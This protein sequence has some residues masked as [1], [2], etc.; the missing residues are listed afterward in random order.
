VGT[1]DPRS[2]RLSQHHREHPPRQQAGRSGPGWRK[3]PIAR[4]GCWRTRTRSISTSC[5]TRTTSSGNRPRARCWIPK[6]L[7]ARLAA[8][9]RRLR[10]ALERGG[11]SDL[12][13]GARD[14]IDPRGGGSFKSLGGLRY[15]SSAS[16]RRQRE[17]P[18][19]LRRSSRSSI[20]RTRTP[21]SARSIPQRAGAR[22]SEAIYSMRRHVFRRELD[23]KQK[24]AYVSARVDYYTQP[25]S[26]RI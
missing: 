26:T 20:R 22:L 25:C 15:W 4:R 9:L 6:S 14:R 12:E 19:D 11:R 13:P 7:R 18:H 1:L 16:I 5:A 24:V 21:C 8:L 17:P 3:L 23:L 2:C 10:A